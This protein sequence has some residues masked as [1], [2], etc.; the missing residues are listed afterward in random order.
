[1]RFQVLTVTSVKMIAFWDIAPRSVVEIDRRF[2]GV[3]RFQIQG[4]GLDD[5]GSTHL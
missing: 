3:Y 2:R 5:G 1:V 4:D